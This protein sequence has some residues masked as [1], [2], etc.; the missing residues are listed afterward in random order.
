MCNA[1]SPLSSSLLRLTGYSNKAA[2]SIP[3]CSCMD[4]AQALVLQHVV[5]TLRQVIHVC[6]LQ[7]VAALHIAKS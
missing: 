6:T 2:T 3:K 5:V 1:E 4:T 7:M